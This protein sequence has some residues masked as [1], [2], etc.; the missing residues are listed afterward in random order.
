M[1]HGDTASPVQPAMIDGPNALLTG[2]RLASELWKALRAFDRALPLLPL[3]QQRSVH[4]QLR[5]SRGRLDS[6]LTEIGLRLTT[7]DGQSYG[8]GLPASAINADEVDGIDELVVTQT[9]EPA[10]V[11]DGQALVQGRVLV[12][13]KETT[14]D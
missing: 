13:K 11:C 12:G 5:F 4:A 10:V 1:G 3:D 6:L 2:A 9:I 7:F 14:Q 8:P